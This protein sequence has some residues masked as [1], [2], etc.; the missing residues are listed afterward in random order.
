[1]EDDGDDRET[2]SVANAEHERLLW[3]TSDSGVTTNALQWL[4]DPVSR[5]IQMN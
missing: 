5:Q 1:M 4:C 3:D 2:I